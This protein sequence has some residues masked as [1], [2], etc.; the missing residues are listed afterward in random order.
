MRHYFMSDMPDLVGRELGVSDWLEVTQELVNGFGASTLD[1]DWMHIDPERAARES[2][3]G[4]PI[5]FGFWTLSMLTHFSHN[6]GMWPRDAAFGLNYGLDRVRWI[7]PVKIGA[8]IRM[9]CTLRGFD[10]RE[11]GGY[12]IRTSNIVE[13]EDGRPALAAEWLGV[14]HPHKSLA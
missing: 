2:P 4:G 9:R 10:P 11:D 6:V 8:R 5:A 13:L 7:N 14:F 3:F 12:L 1:L